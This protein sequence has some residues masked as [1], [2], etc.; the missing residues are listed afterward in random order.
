MR[1]NSESDHILS[2]CIRSIYVDSSTEKTN[3]KEK[4]TGSLI[5]MGHQRTHRYAVAKK[6]TDLIRASASWTASTEFKT[7]IRKGLVP[8]FS[9]RRCKQMSWHNNEYNYKY[10]YSF[11][12][13]SRIFFLR[14][15]VWTT[16]DRPSLSHVTI[17]RVYFSLRNTISLPSPSRFGIEVRG[18][19]F[20]AS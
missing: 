17:M 7:L 20:P 11:S 14:T 5:G 8:G 9:V 13:S 15:F 16:P 4:L 12:I 19:R 6:A 2:I 18:N 3:R 10:I 1:V